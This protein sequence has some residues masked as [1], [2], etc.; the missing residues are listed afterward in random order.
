LWPRFSVTVAV[1]VILVAGIALAGNR[2]GSGARL[3]PTPRLAL[4]PLS[5]LGK[6]QAVGAPG[7]LRPEQIPIPNAPS[8]APAAAVTR[9]ADGIQCL[10][11]EQLAFHIHAHLTVF[12]RGAARGIPYG[13]GIEG[14]QSIST[15]QGIFV[16]GGS[17]FDW[18][19][20]HAAD[21]IIHIESPI[22]RPFT[23]GDFFDV[24]RQKLGPEQVGP[25]RGSVVA[26]YNGHR[27]DGN[28]RQIPLTPHAQIQHEVGRPLVAPLSVHFPAGL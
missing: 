17:G 8:L 24:W 22:V 18:L 25:A 19:H 13:V 21:G 3:I 20:T 2:D 16:A 12:D 5:S 7:P 28:P 15:P 11:G 27:W 26:L 6:L 1:A 10:S 9:P 23:L 14:P 4:S